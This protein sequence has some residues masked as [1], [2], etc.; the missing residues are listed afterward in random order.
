M[1]LHL[2]EHD[3]QHQAWAKHGVERRNL[4]LKVLLSYWYYKNADL[5][6]L[7]VRYFTKPYPEVFADS[8]AFSAMTQNGV[9]NLKEYADW[10]KRYQHLFNAYANLDVIKDAEATWTNQQRLEKMGL[11]PLPVFHIL[12]D[13]KWLEHYLERYQYICLGVA[14][15][16]S[17]RAAV[18]RWL[19]RCFKMANGRAVY[20]GFGLTGW[21][22]MKSFPWYS[23]DSSSWGKG[24][25]WGKVPVFDEKLGK[26]HQPGLGNRKD[27]LKVADIVRSFGFD[28]LDFADRERNDRMKIC[29]ISALS[30]MI[31]EQWLRKR[32]GEIRIPKRNDVSDSKI[33]LVTAGGDGS[34]MGLRALSRYGVCVHLSDISNGV[35]FR[36]ADKGIKLHLADSTTGDN[37]DIGR[38]GKYLE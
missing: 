34:N 12:E 2:A 28:P 32:H 8:G 23:V 4:R 36:D 38:V 33:C 13:W 7:F 24:F 3:L 30:Y 22:V 31:A 20:H 15:M 11:N 18:M 1:K 35:N 14:G 10:I 5:D 6:D 29:A 26:F 25:R 16:Q 19:T 21:D 17:R 27:W 37:F 9:V